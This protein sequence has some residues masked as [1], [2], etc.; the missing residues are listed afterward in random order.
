MAEF[1]TTEREWNMAARSQNYKCVSCGE[2]IPFEGRAL[3]LE[4]SL[5]A[6]CAQMIAPKDDK[7]SA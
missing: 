3:F 1:P 6:Y 4:R 5:C 2:I 7:R